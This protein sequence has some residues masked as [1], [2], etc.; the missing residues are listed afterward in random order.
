MNVQRFLD[1]YLFILPF[2][3]LP[4]DRN[5]FRETRV[6]ARIVF[7][8]ECNYSEPYGNWNICEWIV[9]FTNDLQ[10]AAGGSE[11]LRSGLR[12]QRTEQYCR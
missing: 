6:L 9:I 10:D 5:C 1:M 7:E 3:S 4:D 12:F 11:Y 2:F 8:M